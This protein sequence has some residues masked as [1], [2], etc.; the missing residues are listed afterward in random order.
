MA[1]KEAKH[2]WTAFNTSYK[3]S[4]SQPGYGAG[5]GGGWGAS[6]G[7]GRAGYQAGGAG[8]A[9]ISGTSRTLSN[10]GTIYGST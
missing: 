9:A 5:G 6:G 2:S 4:D 8:G 3:Y 10:S 7:Q 1:L